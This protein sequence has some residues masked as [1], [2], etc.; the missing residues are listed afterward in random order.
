LL[1][2]A[3]LVG[4]QPDLGTALL[5]LSAGLFV[6]FLA[7]LEKRYIF[8]AIVAA[9]SA[10]P[11]FWIFLLHDYQR[12]RI[13]TMLDPQ[14]DKL[15]AGWNIIQ[16]TTAIGSGG[17]NGKGW[18]QGT[19]SQLDFLPESHTDF[20]IAVLAEEY[21]LVGVVALLSLY[22]LIIWRGLTISRNAQSMFGRLLAGSITLT[23][24]VYIFVNMGMVSGIL[25]V[26]GVP[27]PFVSYGG[28]AIVTLM[29]GFGMLM[30]ISTERKR[31]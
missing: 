31:N 3:V 22:L 6:L 11:V 8:G 23:F 13:L 21:G 18:M 20:I 1:I 2:P 16:S 7:G 24:F 29:L 5:I 27:L 30:S 28:T 25:P 14:A 17:L 9:L 4:L 26:V 15:G 12:Q 19:Q 10:A